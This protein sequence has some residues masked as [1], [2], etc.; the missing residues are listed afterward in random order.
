MGLFDSFLK[1]GM[2]K[3]TEQVD[4][5]SIKDAVGINKNYDNYIVPEKYSNFPVYNGSLE[6]KPYESD[7]PKYSRLTL[8]YSG[9]PDI[10]YFTILSANGFSKASDVRFDKGNT[11]VIVEDNGGSTKIAYHIKK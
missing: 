9:A 7:T 1:E 5:N 6:S 8:F 10:N 4:I 3:I 11:Y 2:K